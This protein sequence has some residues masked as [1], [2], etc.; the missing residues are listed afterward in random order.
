MYQ[1]IKLFYFLAFLIA[2]QFPLNAQEKKPKVALVLSGG[3]AKGIAHIPVLQKLDSLGIVPDLVVGTSM[4][5]VVG[6]LYSMGYSGNDIAEMITELDWN[7]LLGGSVTLALVGNEEKSEFNNYLIG[8][9]WKNKKPSISTGILN[10]QNLRELLALLTYPVY[11]IHDFDKLPIPY[12]AIATDIVSGNEVVIK[13]GSLLTAMRASMSIPSIF[14]PV[15]YKETLL[16]DGGILNNFPTDVAKQLGADIIIGSDVGGGLKTKEELNNIATILFQ[17]SMLVSSIKNPEN[18]KLCDVLVDHTPNLTYST[19]DFNRSAGIYEEGKI[20]TNEQTDPLSELAFKLRNYEQRQVKVPEVP[21][22]FVLDTIVYKS[23]SKGNLELVKS[24]VDLEENKAYAPDDVVN[25]V[26]RLMGTNLFNQIVVIPKVK[27]SVLGLEINGVENSKHQLK[28][29]LHY[30][31]YRDLGAIINY[32]GRNVVGEASRT[33]FTLD[34]SEQPKLRVQHQKIFGKEHKWWWR[35]ELLWLKLKQKVYFDGF[36]VDGMKYKSL[37][38]DF[39]F[40]RNL[41]V[42]KSYIG[43][44]LASNTVNLEPQISLATEDSSILENYKFKDI[45]LDFHFN[46]NSFDEVF[47]SKRGTFVH[48]SIE[49]SLVH[50]VDLNFSDESENL[51]GNTNG[52]TKANVVYERRIPLNGLFSIIV[53]AQGAFTFQQDLTGDDISF[54]DFGYGAKYFIGGNVTRPMRDTFVFAGLDEDELTATQ[55][56]AFNLGVQYHPFKKVYIQPHGSLA[57]VGFDEFSNYVDHAFS[58]KGNWD[59]AQET[60]A[61][62]S[63]GSTFSYNSLLGPINLD[64]SYVNGL[65][66]FRV[67]LGIGFQ[68]GKSN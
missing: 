32:T 5:S 26:N 43:L 62:L 46:Y 14:K 52:F 67:F 47:Y 1:K 57:S 4:G 33:L 55:F 24:R 28:L 29:A 22:Q 34:V 9:N 37:A 12:R 63:V 31:T 36:G 54:S 48:A 49:Q 39:Q 41:I 15:D 44:G 66:R 8:L 16:V 42:N 50:K 56:L 2:I 19:G 25:G 58:P 6:G 60:S 20:A 18:R 61:V 35:T 3:G 51:N 40:N 27:D 23:I 17:T 45:G 53:G 59:E 13:E 65:D 10:D 30:D 64:V 21:E 7:Q 68:F 11:S 38:F